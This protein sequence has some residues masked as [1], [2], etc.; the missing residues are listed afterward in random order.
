MRYG[1]FDD[2]AC[3]YVITRPD[4]PLP[5]INYLGSEAYFGLIS[6]TAGGYSFYK[7]ARLRR[8]TRYRYNNTPLDENGRYIYIRDDGAAKP[9]FW[10]PTWQ[11]V[12]IGLENYEC[13]H[14]MGYTRI[15]SSTKGIAA[16]TLYF[17]PPGQNLEVWS[18]EITNQRDRKAELSVF[19][20]IEFCLWDAVD[21]PNNFQRN[22][23]IGEVEVED[24]II[25]HKSEY[26]ERR[27]HFAYFACSDPLTG[28]DT[29][30]EAF[31]GTYRGW[32]NPARCGNRAMLGFD[33]SR[34]AADRCAPH[35]GDTCTRRNPPD[36][37][38]TRLPR[39]PGCRKIQST[40]LLHPE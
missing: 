16:S 13:R 1:F 38:S 29:N 27:N 23:S 21:D 25:F 9:T 22:Y 37:F 30:R 14:G 6:N 15:S 31:L 11:P 7:D 34:L 40:R 32:S 33:R 3:E 18:L 24:G 36:R 5:W 19:S 20:A 2:Q 8:I 39:E 12:R 28:F 4:T 26:R 10:S 35:Q 17:V